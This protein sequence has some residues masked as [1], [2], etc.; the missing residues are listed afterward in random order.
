VSGRRRFNMVSP[1]LEEYIGKSTV[2]QVKQEYQTKFLPEY[3]P[4]VKQ[5]RRV[6]ARLL[7]YAQ[8]SGLQNTEWEVH[9]IDSPQQNAFVAP[10]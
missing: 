5:V 6:L 1:A 7:P 3:D 4:R 9:V 2:E 8:G 10:G